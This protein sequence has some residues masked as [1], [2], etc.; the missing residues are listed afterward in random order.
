M[1][2]TSGVEPVYISIDKPEM[3]A[4]WLEIIQRKKLYGLHVFASAELAEDLRTEHRVTAI[5]RYMLINPQGEII[6][7]HAPRPGNLHLLE[8]ALSGLLVKSSQL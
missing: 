4:R 2:L 6:H 3:K 1:F 7:S 8:I 5:P